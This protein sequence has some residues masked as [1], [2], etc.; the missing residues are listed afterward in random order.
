RICSSG[1]RSF[2]RVPKTSRSPSD[3][4]SSPA[5]MEISVVLPQP[6]GPTSMA[7]S[8]MAISRSRPRRACAFASPTPNDLV[9]PSHTTARSI[10]LSYEDYGWIKNQQFGDYH[11]RRESVNE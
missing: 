9:I 1:L 8:P 10:F 5:M 3:G 4:S 6:E 7:S 2:D 11:Y